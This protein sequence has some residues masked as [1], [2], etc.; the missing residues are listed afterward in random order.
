MALTEFSSPVSPLLARM[1]QLIILQ[2]SG[3]TALDR[4][5]TSI[6]IPTSTGTAKLIQKPDVL[7]YSHFFP[8]EILDT[9][10]SYDLPAFNS[11]DI[12]LAPNTLKEIAGEY[13]ESYYDGNGDEQRS[14]TATTFTA[15]KSGLG[16]LLNEYDF[17]NNFL[18]SKFLSSVG[19]ST[20]RKDAQQFL[21]FFLRNTGSVSFNV[22][23]NFRYV[24]GT[25]HEH[26]IHSYTAT[27][28]QGMHLYHIPCGWE[29]C[30][31]EA[32]AA[33]EVQ[34]YEIY[35]QNTSGALLS[36]KVRFIPTTEKRF[37][38]L[39]FFN[40][41]GGVETFY[42][43]G[44]WEETNDLKKQVIERDLPHNHV[45]NARQSSTSE[46]TQK[47]MFKVSTG[48]FTSKDKLLI[49]ELLQSKE[50]Y[51]IDE[52][53]YIPINITT[54]KYLTQRS[55]PALNAVEFTYEYAFDTSLIQEIR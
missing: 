51:E 20:V 8:N 4:Y 38:G 53:A 39:L 33:Q 16:H 26:Q 5:R 45:S 34:Y 2:S 30:G 13:V 10:L 28:T 46:V 22:F 40:S 23:V 18:E 21:T 25:T 29:Q 37:K 9:L 32:L 24:D 44:N 55:E 11:S 27:P 50:V 12:E 15:I 47:T 1:R 54:S 3:Y 31:M 7:G 36:E 19:L 14:A 17:L 42:C 48:Y 49:N 41:M 52:D 35:V 6:E 43:A